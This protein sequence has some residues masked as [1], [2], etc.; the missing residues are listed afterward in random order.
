MRFCRAE[1]GTA[2][3]DVL[4]VLVCGAIVLVMAVP[5]LEKIQEEWALWSA[6]HLVE[7]SLFWGRMHAISTNCPLRFEVDQGGRRVH[8]EDAETGEVLE[9]SRWILPGRT[10]ITGMPRRPLRF[11]PKGTAAPSGTYTVEGSAGKYR[12]IVAITGRI[13]SRRN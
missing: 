11:Y 6:A 7:T 3:V 13:R 8:W 1:S 4:I 12:V 2:L 9:N 10:G 5:G